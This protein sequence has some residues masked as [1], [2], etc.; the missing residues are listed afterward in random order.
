MIEGY[1]L[2]TTT[3]TQDYQNQKEFELAKKKAES[4]RFWTDVS[5]VAGFLVFAA[6]IIGG[7]IALIASA[8]PRKW[9]S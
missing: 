6:G 5:L 9:K 8:T 7:M 4:K 3:M 2:S 1:K